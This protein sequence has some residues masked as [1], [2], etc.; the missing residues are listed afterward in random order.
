MLKEESMEPSEL[1]TEI[2]KLINFPVKPESEWVICFENA[3]ESAIAGAIAS[4]QLH[5][6]GLTSNPGDNVS[7]KR[8][9]ATAILNYRLS[10][11]TNTTMIKLDES[12]TKLS[13]VM[14]FLSV[15]GLILS[16]IQLF[17]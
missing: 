11:T 1:Q 8:E 10:N 17:K 16:V 4:W 13:Y 7:N 15:V 5:G 3:S 6:G 2:N 12:T 14:V 9:A